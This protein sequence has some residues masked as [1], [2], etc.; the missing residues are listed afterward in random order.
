MKTARNLIN[1]GVEYNSSPKVNSFAR[2]SRKEYSKLTPSF[3][4]FM[5]KVSTLLHQISSGI[6][7]ADNMRAFATASV[8]ERISKLKLQA[9]LNISDMRVFRASSCTH[10]VVLHISSSETETPTY[11]SLNCAEKWQQ[12]VHR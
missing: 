5:F 2:P 10:Y 12:R 8:C 7:S 6:H 11:L 9:N 3:V 1:S 4:Q